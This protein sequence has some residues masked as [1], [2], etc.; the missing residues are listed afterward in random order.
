MGKTRRAACSLLWHSGRLRAHLLRVR[1]HARVIF[2]V[3]LQGRASR[4]V[5]IR[6]ATPVP[7]ASSPTP[8]A[9]TTPPPRASR[10]DL[11]PGPRVLFRCTAPSA[12]AVPAPLT[13]YHGTARA[14]PVRAGHQDA[15][16]SFSSS[17]TLEGASGLPGSAERVFLALCLVRTQADRTRTGTWTMFSGKNGVVRTARVNQRAGPFVDGRAHAH[18]LGTR[19]MSSHCTPG[20]LLFPGKSRHWN[21][22]TNRAEDSRAI[23]YIFR[24]MYL[25]LVPIGFL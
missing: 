15:L 21:L 25:R 14:R 20:V 12:I 2:G 5:S 23:M 22:A 13:V 11:S 1:A 17:S 3:F 18:S 24:E 4:A 16:A 19:V 8:V 9:H 10:R 6:P 7:A